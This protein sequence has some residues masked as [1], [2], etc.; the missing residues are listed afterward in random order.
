MISSSACTE[1]TIT[2]LF[3]R[4]PRSCRTWANIGW[5]FPKTPRAKNF[6][7]AF[8]GQRG[9]DP[10]VFHFGT[11]GL[12]SKQNHDISPHACGVERGANVVS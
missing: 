11:F 1:A 7:I 3:H 5:A 9:F 6:G 10:A 8:G 12:D 2:K 4:Q